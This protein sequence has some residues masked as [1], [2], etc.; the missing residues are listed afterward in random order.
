MLKPEKKKNE[1]CQNRIGVLLVP[2][3][4]VPSLKKPTHKLTEEASEQGCSEAFLS[5]LYRAFL[6]AQL[7]GSE[8]CG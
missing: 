8:L 2:L 5:G 4:L 3:P 1:F 7:S 6:R